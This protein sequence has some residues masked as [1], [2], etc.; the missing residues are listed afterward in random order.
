M[1]HLLSTATIRYAAFIDL[2]KAFDMVDHTRLSDLLASYRCPD[3]IHYLIRSLTFRGLRSCILV[4]NQLSGWFSRTRSVLQGSPLS[5]YLFNIYID[6]LIS[7]LNRS[8]I[9]VP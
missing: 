8:P 4:N 7:G 9:S 1:H 5:P 3:H 2:E 6:E